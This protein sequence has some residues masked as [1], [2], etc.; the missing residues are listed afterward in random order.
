[1][2]RL[3]L[4]GSEPE[5]ALGAVRQWTH[6]PQF[7]EGHVSVASPQ[8]FR[9]LVESAAG[10]LA[11]VT[12]TLRMAPDRILAAGLAS[13]IDE[14]PFA[15]ATRERIAGEFE[16]RHGLAIELLDINLDEDNPLEL[17]AAIPRAIAQAARKLGKPGSEKVSLS[18]LRTSVTEQVAVEWQ[19]TKSEFVSRLN[20]EAV[21][22]ARAIDGLMPST[23]SFLNTVGA[24]RRRNRA[25]AM[26]AFPLLRPILMLPQLDAVRTAIDQGRPLIDVLAEHFGASKAMIRSL[27]GATP[28]DLGHLAGHVGTVVEL[29]REIPANWWPREP[30]AWRQFANA[31]NTIAAVSR[32]PITT[33]TNRLWLRHCGQSN[34]RLP[35][36][37]PEHLTR[38]GQEIDEFMDILRRALYWVLPDSIHASSNTPRR[39]PMEIMV[40]LKVDL[41]LNRL[42]QLAR[43]F[44]DAYRTAVTEFAEEAELWN[45]VRWPAIGEG[46]REY[47]DILVHPLLNPAELKEEGARMQSCVAGY[48][49]RCMKGT[50]QIWSVRLRDGTRL[51]TLETRIRARSNG[52]MVLEIQ[53]HKGMRNGAPT[54]LASQ[55]VQAHAAYLSESSERM[56]QYVVWKQTI[57]RRPLDVRQRH[58]VMQPIITAL[59]Q[60]LHGKWSWNNLVAAL[61]SDT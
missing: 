13:L 41:G 11:I 4:T 43:R 56:T 28:E 24:E 35:E 29:L 49:E 42:T 30:V 17:T 45:G 46:P 10:R 59:K 5:F 54:A 23:Y 55:A 6:F 27:R 36:R 60:T 33:A 26:S 58:A 21:A 15:N 12:V 50:S 53:Q 31:A 14:V 44:G 40:E 38:L 2:D 61:G 18:A 20:A 34:Y 25:Q 3:Q 8:T 32:H 7:A 16:A 37:T 47:G 39:R 22:H 1:M 57:S 9:V 52:R 51:S 48:V 19:H